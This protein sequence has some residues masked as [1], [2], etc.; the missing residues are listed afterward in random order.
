[1]YPAKLHTRQSPARHHLR[2]L[3]AAAGLGVAAWCGTG[4]AHANPDHEREACALMDDSASAIHFGYGTSTPQYAYAVLSAEMPADVA[5][6]VV[7]AATRNHCPSHAA[8][9]PPG[10]R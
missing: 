9:L 4:I 7:S 3:A 2:A 5:A 6:Q 10:W 1:M 8:E